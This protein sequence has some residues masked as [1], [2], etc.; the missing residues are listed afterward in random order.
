MTN[1]PENDD[2][3]SALLENLDIDTPPEPTVKKEPKGSNTPKQ[4]EDS[5]SEHLD[6]NIPKHQKD[7]TVSENSDAKDKDELDLI[8]LHNN[9]LRELLTNYRKDRN[10]LDSYIALLYG[11][12]KKSEPSRVLFEALAATLRTK[13][14]SNSNLIK[15]LDIINKRIDKN[16]GGEE[17]NLENLLDD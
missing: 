10:D 15:L 6:S 3:L 7:Q 13:C 12:L 17:L 8:A 16:G 11:G 14:E 9:S 5:V 1:M 4:S 2:E